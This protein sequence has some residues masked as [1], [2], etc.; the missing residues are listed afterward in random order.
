METLERLPTNFETPI[1]TEIILPPKS[2]PSA[3]V[4]SI[5]SGRLLNTVELEW[6]PDPPDMAA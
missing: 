4:Y 3:N 1:V 2:E 6:L 5:W